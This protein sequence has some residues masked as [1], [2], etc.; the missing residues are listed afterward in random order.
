MKGLPK[1]I[2]RFQIWI[3]KLIPGL[4]IGFFFFA[5]IFELIKNFYPPNALSEYNDLIPV[6]SFLGM[7][8]IVT[9][10]LI[11]VKIINHIIKSNTKSEDNQN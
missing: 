1:L 4:L 10:A 11:S 2:R 7:I 3:L 8:M 9:M 5:G 6:F